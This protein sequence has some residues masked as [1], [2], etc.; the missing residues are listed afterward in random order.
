MV[1]I[2]DEI[3]GC[4]DACDALPAADGT[5]RRGGDGHRRSHRVRLVTAFPLNTYFLCALF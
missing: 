3:F 1:M 4:A 5:G 2:L